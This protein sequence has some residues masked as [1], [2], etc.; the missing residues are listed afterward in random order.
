M[1]SIVSSPYGVNTSGAPIGP[2][3]YVLC[4]S[5]GRETQEISKETALPYAYCLC[6]RPESLTG[7]HH[8]VST[9]AVTS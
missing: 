2:H 5:C 3:G 4:Q 1:K 6:H 9:K 8:A 7:G